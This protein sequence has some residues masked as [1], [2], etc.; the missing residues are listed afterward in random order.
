MGHKV[1]YGNIPEYQERKLIS[2]EMTVPIWK[3]WDHNRMDK[4][5]Q[6]VDKGRIKD[7]QKRQ[8]KKI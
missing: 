7:K 5:V 8:G 3:I 2:N 1:K 4:P 6:K